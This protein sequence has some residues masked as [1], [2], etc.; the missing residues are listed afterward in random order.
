MWR[1]TQVKSMKQDDG[2]SEEEEWDG[3]Q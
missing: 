3:L 1:A 2:G